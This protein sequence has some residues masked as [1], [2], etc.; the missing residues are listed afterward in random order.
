MTNGRLGIRLLPLVIGT[1][2]LVTQTLLAG[3][4]L[5]LAI[6]IA[7][8]TSIFSVVDAVLLRPLPYEGSD[9]LVMLEAT[10]PEDGF[11]GMGR[12]GTSFLIGNSKPNRSQQWLVFDG[13]F[14]ELVEDDTY[15]RLEG[16]QV[17]ED[18]LKVLKARPSIGQ[19]VGSR[20]AARDEIALSHH[21]WED[22]FE[23]SSK[24]IG[25][26]VTASN[27]NTWLNRVRQ[28]YP[29]VGVLPEG[30][31]FLPTR[32]WLVDS[33]V[34]ID[35]DMDFCQAI[36]AK[37]NDHRCW[38]K[39]DVVARLEPGVSVSQ[40]QAEMDV[41]ADRLALMYPDTNKGWRIEVTQLKQNI[42]G[43]YEAALHLLFTAV[44]CE[45]LIVCVNVAHL[46]LVRASARQAEVATR[47]ALGASWW[48]LVRQ[49]MT[50]SLLLAALGGGLGILL[51]YWSIDVLLALVPE[52]TTRLGEVAIK[53]QVL[54][55][56]L[57]V[58]L[59]TGLLLGVVPAL[60]LASANINELL[61]SS[62]GKAAGS[63][64]WARAGN[65][66]VV[67]ELGV[68]LMLLVGAGSL[69]KSFSQVMNVDPGFTSTK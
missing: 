3:T 32:T 16:L 64:L 19:F 35:R 49:L 40:A 1:W 38:R 13:H 65:L 22:R 58:T 36:N 62:G 11:T 42:V 59:A 41:I 68:T 47:S 39:L 31:K 23:K 61:K 52:G 67:V 17:S 30:L 7:A 21:L 54:W 46:L 15:T 43:E 55:F 29:V 69:I 24:L 25:D 26:A 53:G 9:E 20:P 37:A 34:G 12:P 60:Q 48:R 50:E 5:S 33:G 14:F 2:T 8:T 56:A 27:W 45:L 10:H 57:L 51:T 44:G 28:S 63:R 4:A 18:F 6:G 66:F